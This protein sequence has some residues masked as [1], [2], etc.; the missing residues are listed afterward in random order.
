VNV[1]WPRW[2]RHGWIVVVLAVGAAWPVSAVTGKARELVVQADRLQ[3]APDAS[4][5]SARRA[6]ALYEEAARLEPNSAEIQLKLADTALTIA[7]WT[8]DDRLRWYQLGQGAA[9]RAVAL[10]QNNAEALFLLAANRGQIASLQM[11][12]GGLL[13]PQQLERLLSRAL[14]V[15]PRH[16]RALHMMGMLLYRTPAPLRLLLKGSASDAEPYLV[17]AIEADPN[18]SEARLDLARYYASRGQTSQ[19]RTQIHAVLQMT[20]PTRPRAWREKHRPAAEALL[21]ELPA[22]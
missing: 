22:E 6:I 8:S 17:A 3:A 14:A 21:K 16:A 13:V 7:A 15:N 20:S 4:N 19:A 1:E 12:L 11:D 2:P 10:D 18:F 9:E 5:E